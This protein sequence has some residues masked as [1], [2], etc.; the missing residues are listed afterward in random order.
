[1]PDHPPSYPS[2][3]VGE[4]RPNACL[5][6]EEASDKLMCFPGKKKPAP[7]AGTG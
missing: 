1:M 3:N 2:T 5:E 4:W 7:I 6:L